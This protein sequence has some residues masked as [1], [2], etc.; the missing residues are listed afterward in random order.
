MQ[1]SINAVVGISDNSVSSALNSLPDL[2]VRFAANDDA[3]SSLIPESNNKKVKKLS[4]FNSTTAYEFDRQLSVRQRKTDQFQAA[5]D[6]NLTDLE[7]LFNENR[8]NPRIF[9]NRLD[10]ETKLTA[11]HYAARFHH[12]DIC[13]YLIKNCEA[14]VNKAGEDGMTPLHY[15]ARFRVEKDSPADSYGNVIQYLIYHGANINACD[16][17][18]AT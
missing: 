13:E 7:N 16:I 11:L 5:R 2:H 8:S 10:P 14:N 15:I 12:L 1:R 4:R 6:G 9:F 18:Q 17:F 3:A